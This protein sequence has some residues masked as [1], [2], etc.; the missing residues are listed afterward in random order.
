[1]KQTILVLIFAFTMIGILNSCMSREERNK[2]AEE[3]GRSRIEEQ[4]SNVKGMGEALKEAGKEA[5][6]S[7]TEGTGNVIKGANEGFDQSLVKIDIRLADNAKEYCAATR[8]RVDTDSLGKK[9]VISYM[10]FGKAC[11]G[12]LI[13]KMFDKADQEIARSV[14]HVDKMEDEAMNVEFPFDQ[15]TSFMLI[16]YGTLEYKQ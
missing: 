11:K 14:I 6:E 7:L 3:K 9:Q 15:R 5:M 13:M 4:A 10:T 1:M 8:T 16:K 12:K 2:R